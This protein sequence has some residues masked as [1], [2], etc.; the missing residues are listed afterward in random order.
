MK[1]VID[2]TNRKQLATHYFKQNHND[3]TVNVSNLKTIVKRK[4]LPE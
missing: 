3:N 1:H 4:E 2:G